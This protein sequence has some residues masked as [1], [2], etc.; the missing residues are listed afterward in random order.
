MPGG[1]SRA[2][3]PLALLAASLL[4]IAAWTLV[5]TL[6]FVERSRWSGPAHDAWYFLSTVRRYYRGEAILSDMLQWHGGHRPFFPRLLYLVDYLGFR[7][8]NAFPIACGLGLQAALAGALCRRAWSERRAVPRPATWLLIAAPPTLLFSATQLVNLARAW[9]VHWF[10]ACAAG[11]GAVMALVRARDALAASRPVAAIAAG[12]AACAAAAVS[13]YSMAI[14]LVVWPVLA[15]LG[16]ALR[17]PAAGLGLA[18]LAALAVCGP[19]FVDYD[20]PALSRIPSGAEAVV[21]VARWSARC[22][23]APLSWARPEAGQALGALGMLVAAGAWLRRLVRRPAIRSLEAVYLGMAAFA[24]GAVLLTG[25]AR[26][27]DSEGS[28]ASNRYQ[29]MTLLFWLGLVGLAAVRLGRRG[30][31]SL[32]TAFAA[33]A[34]AVL[35]PAGMREARE[36]VA[37]AEQVRAAHDAIVVGILH[38]SAYGAVLPVS[39]SRKGIDPVREVGP[40]LRAHELGMFADG[41]HHWLGRRVEEALGVSEACEGGIARVSLIEDPGVVAVRLSGWAWDLASDSP[42]SRVWVTDR[43]GE[44]IGLGSHVRA[45]DALREAPPRARASAWLAHARPPTRGASVR[46]WARVGDGAACRIAGS[47]RVR[48][49]G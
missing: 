8:T 32:G 31:A 18:A 4:A 16:F 30:A 23:G 38:P 17:L 37:H 35:I 11:V 9:N 19:Y 46:V 43:R 45:G 1:A 41:A 14:G 21:A 25:L 10:L 29:T 48:D 2:R 42:V 36:A 33:W 26:V 20:P 5:S 13:T 28:W 3:I 27:A 49:D 6:Y 47:V 39:M 7:G 15:L 40:F 34:A 22:L 44:I 12:C 24:L